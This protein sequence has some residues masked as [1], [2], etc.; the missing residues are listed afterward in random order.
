LRNLIAFIDGLV[1]GAIYV[2]VLVMGLSLA[3]LGVYVVTFLCYRV[4]QFLHRVLL[5]RVW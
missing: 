4:G 3:V 2:M 5:G 1:R